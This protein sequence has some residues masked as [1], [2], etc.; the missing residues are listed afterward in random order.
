MTDH[1][2]A[3]WPVV[4]IASPYTIGDK[5]YNVARQMR[6]AHR[7][8]DVQIS[9][10][11]PLLTHFLELMEHRDEEHWMQM[12]LAHVAKADAVL[13]L[14]GQSAGADREVA[15]AEE[16]EI[17]VFFTPKM[18]DFALSPLVRWSAQWRSSHA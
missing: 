6:L 9:P 14:Y 4:Y 17:P 1:R 11:V 2:H 7:L 3:G 10:I 5:T 12:D 15:L 16:L 8:I 18:Q 13:R